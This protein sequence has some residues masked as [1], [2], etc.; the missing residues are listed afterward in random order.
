MQEVL[1]QI[2]QTRRRIATNPEPWFC[3]AHEAPAKHPSFDTWPRM[4]ERG[5]TVEDMTNVLLQ[6]CSKATAAYQNCQA[7]LGKI[8]AA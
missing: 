4:A 7:D 6:I 5:K 1:A 2:K 3:G 8:V